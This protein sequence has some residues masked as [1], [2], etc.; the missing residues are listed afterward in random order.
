MSISLLA[1][2]ACSFA[3][4]RSSCAVEVESSIRAL[5]AAVASLF[6]SCL[7]FLIGGMLSLVGRAN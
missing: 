2:A 5:A 7:L 4:G 1:S 3:S 6:A